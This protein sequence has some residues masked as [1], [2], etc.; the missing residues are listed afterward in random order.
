MVQNGV[1]AYRCPVDTATRRRL[2]ESGRW[3]NVAVAV[4]DGRQVLHVMSVYGYTGASANNVAKR[5]NE[6]LLQDV[7]E[8]AVELGNV[9]VMI[10]GDFNV[11]PSRSATIQNAL[12]TR[13]WR[14]VATKIAEATGHP[15]VATCFKSPSGTRIDAAIYTCAAAVVSDFSV[16]QDSGLP[17]HRP[18]VATMHRR[19]YS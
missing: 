6:R 3:V 8:T 16:L 13:G 14:D 4:A 19:E 5:Q 15:V 1:D 12:S 18:I 11:D 9:P 17:T 7:F 2:W 10:L